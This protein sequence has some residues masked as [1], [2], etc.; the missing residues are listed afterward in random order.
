LLVDYLLKDWA[1]TIANTVFI[2]YLYKAMRNFYG[3]GRVKTIV[4]FIL[5]NFIFFILAG[6]AAII[7]ILASFAIY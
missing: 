2:F 7:S 5:L 3:Q 6:I 1:L 4:K